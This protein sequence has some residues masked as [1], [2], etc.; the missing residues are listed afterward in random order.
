MLMRFLA[1]ERLGQNGATELSTT[2]AQLKTKNW[3]FPVVEFYLGRRTMKE[4]RVAGSAPYEQCEATFYIGE[5]QLLRGNKAEAQRELQDAT[6][7]CHK[8]SNEYVG[9]VAEL[10]RLNPMVGSHVVALGPQYDQWNVVFGSLN[11]V[12]G[13]D[14]YMFVEPAPIEYPRPGDGIILKCSPEADTQYCVL[15]AVRKKK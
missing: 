11:S 5:L 8:A 2:A 15:V 9:A 10:R 13:D 4:M 6:N 1:R 14:R 7:L 12:N 3:P